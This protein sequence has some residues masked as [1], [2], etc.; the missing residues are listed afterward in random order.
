MSHERGNSEPIKDAM[1]DDQLYRVLDKDDW[2]NDTIHAIKRTPL[3]HQDKN[4]KRRVTA[5][6]RKFYW[7]APYLYR[8]EENG[9]LRRCISIEERK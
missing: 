7:H 5:E 8:Y 1:R 2:M 9:V 6:N 4:T 3:D